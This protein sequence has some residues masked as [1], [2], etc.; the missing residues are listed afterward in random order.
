M[1]PAKPM[2]I[3]IVFNLTSIESAQTVDFDKLILCLHK[4]IHFYCNIEGK[5]YTSSKILKRDILPVIDKV[6]SAV[7]DFLGT[8]S[9]LLVVPKTMSETLLGLVSVQSIRPSI[10]SFHP[11]CDRLLNNDDLD[12]DYRPH[13]QRE[14]DCSLL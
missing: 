14:V 9:A 8:R 13:T 12:F 11:G 6:R 7:F 5:E 4:A 10:D 1:L 2:K 3:K